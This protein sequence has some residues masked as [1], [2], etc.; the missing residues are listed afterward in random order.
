MR[1]QKDLCGR[2]PARKKKEAFLHDERKQQRCAV[3]RG[4]HSNRYIIANYKTIDTNEG[5]EENVSGVYGY[6]AREKKSKYMI[7]IVVN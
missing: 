4:K 1:F 7:N 2:M 3:E 6:A 5:T